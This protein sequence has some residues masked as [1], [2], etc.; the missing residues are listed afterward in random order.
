M[1]YSKKYL[2]GGGWVLVEV[3]KII[4]K[5]RG[6]SSVSLWMNM[7]RQ[8]DNCRL[9]SKKHASQIGLSL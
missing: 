3:E 1:L 2:F 9:M 4:I 7:N 6:E 8:M 5:I